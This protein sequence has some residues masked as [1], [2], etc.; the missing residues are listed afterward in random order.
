MTLI[1]DIAQR[2]DQWTLL[3]RYRRLVRSRGE[4]ERGNAIQVLCGA[5]QLSINSG[6]DEAS[7]EIDGG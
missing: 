5:C 6:P 7:S 2:R 1:C 4:K 3:T